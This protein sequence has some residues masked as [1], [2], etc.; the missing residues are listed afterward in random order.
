[1]PTPSTSKIRNSII[2]FVIA[3]AGLLAG[4]W[5][6]DNP[7]ETDSSGVLTKPRPLVAFTLTRHD[8]SPFNLAS[9]R[10]KWTFLFFGY[11]HCPD[12]CPT[13][14]AELSKLQTMLGSD[15]SVLN[16]TQFVFV[17]VDPERD[18]PESLGDYV[19]Y[20]NETF[21]GA[22]G[23]KEQLARIT[24]QFDIKHSRGDVTSGG[25]TVNHSSAVLLVDPQTRYYARLRAPH[26]AEDVLKR[27]LAIRN[28][29]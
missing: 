15:N 22:T 2:F 14:L 25:Y 11:T 27:Y 8:Q 4:V 7:S 21:I 5:I 6:S 10:G 19:H 3:I 1:M 18:T 12:V 9:L 13:T 28:N 24:A 16:N 26:Y 17:S 23:T 20:F 29:Y